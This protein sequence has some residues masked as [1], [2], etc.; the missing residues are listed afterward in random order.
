MVKDSPA[1][2]PINRVKPKP[3]RREIAERSMQSAISMAAVVGA[4]HTFPVADASQADKPPPENWMACQMEKYYIERGAAGIRVVK[5]SLQVHVD[6]TTIEAHT[7]KVEKKYQVAFKAANESGKS[8][9]VWTSEKQTR[10]DVQFLTVIKGVN[11]AGANLP[12]VVVVKG[13][14]DTEL[15][16]AEAENGVLVVPV[17]GFCIGAGANPNAKDVG[18]VVFMRGDTTGAHKLVYKWYLEHVVQGFIHDRRQELM[19]AE[20]R[21][22]LPQTVPDAYKAVVWIDGEISAIGAVVPTESVQTW[23]ALKIDVC[24]VPACMTGTAQAL[25]VGPIFRCL[26]TLEKSINANDF[27]PLAN[28]QALYHQSIRDNPKLHNLTYR[29]LAAVTNFMAI[30]PVIDTRASS[31]VNIINS[32]VDV[33]MLGARGDPWPVWEKLALGTCRRSL[34][35]DE[36]QLARDKFFDVLDVIISEG[37][38]SDEKL[39]QFGFPV[40]TDARGQ[41]AC[42]RPSG[43]KEEHRQ[44]AKC[45]THRRQIQMREEVAQLVKAKSREREVTAEKQAE[46]ML[47]LNRECELVVMKE[48]GVGTPPPFSARSFAGV[49][50]QSFEKANTK[51]L[52]G[53]VFARSHGNGHGKKLTCN[54]GTAASPSTEPTLLRE[55]FDRRADKVILKSSTTASGSSGTPPAVPIVVPTADPIGGKS[56]PSVLASERLGDTAWV[57]AN[58]KALGPGVKKWSQPKGKSTDSRVTFVRIYS[59]IY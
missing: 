24:K 14:S 9:A 55:A 38:A 31:S 47:K 8:R 40:D 53:F 5:P 50:I 41:P 21:C 58:M 43:P 22:T 2:V 7:A 34:T 3:E 15:P 17:H 33:G 11:G 54:K 56:M 1:V 26:K 13:L 4:S 18:Y 42:S 12:E 10:D 23:N 46:E 48:H 37:E 16:V 45:L 20:F 28:L 36:Q 27:A 51:Q 19:Q 6:A 30:L 35:N 25:D 59:Y 52:Q 44:R 49:Q 39:T 29:R 32:L 57:Q